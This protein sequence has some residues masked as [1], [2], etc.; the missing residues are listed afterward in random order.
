MADSQTA[1]GGALCRRGVVFALGS[2]LVRR[3][4]GGVA[5]VAS[6]SFYFNG[7][8]TSGDSSSGARVGTQRS[9]GGPKSGRRSLFRR[10]VLSVRAFRVFGSATGSRMWAMFPVFRPNRAHNGYLEIYLNLGWI[11]LLMFV[12]V[13]CRSTV[14]AGKARAAIATSSRADRARARQVGIGYLAAYSSTTSR[15]PSSSRSIFFSSS[16]WSSE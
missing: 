1:A 7:R 15:K 12:G 3:Y 14:D 10:T 2:S 8:S 13:L 11:G 9:P 16:S 5:I 6:S 4:F